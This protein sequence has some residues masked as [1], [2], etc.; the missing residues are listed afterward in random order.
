MGARRL[1]SRRAEFSR[2]SSLGINRPKGKCETIAAKQIAALGT[3]CPFRRFA[4]ILFRCWPFF[5]D[6]LGN[7]QLVW[8]GLSLCLQFGK[9][10]ECVLWIIAMPCDELNFSIYSLYQ[11]F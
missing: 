9:K 6:I 7:V 4:N 1:S 11:S 3:C 8:T 2:T 10:K 5:A